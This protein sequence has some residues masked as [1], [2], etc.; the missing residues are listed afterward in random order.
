VATE[1]A[2]QTRETAETPAFPP[3]IKNA[4]L[5]AIFNAFNKRLN[6]EG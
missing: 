6:S 3:G 5:F 2:S 1:E 4:Y